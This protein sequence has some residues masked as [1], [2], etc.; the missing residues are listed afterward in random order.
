MNR[1]PLQSANFEMHHLGSCYHR[2]TGATVGD[3][4][5]QSRGL[6]VREVIPLC[7]PM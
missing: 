5:A 2:T 4:I 7:L 6:I 3:W 1:T